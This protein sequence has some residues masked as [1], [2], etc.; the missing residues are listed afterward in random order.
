MS[1]KCLQRKGH[2]RRGCV[3]LLSQHLGHRRIR[4]PGQSQL[5]S[6]SEVSL[7][8]MRPCQSNTEGW[9]KN[10]R[11][12]KRKERRPGDI[13]SVSAPLYDT[14]SLH[15]LQNQV[16]QLGALQAP[17]T[18]VW[19]EQ[20]TGRVRLTENGPMKKQTKFLPLLFSISAYMMDVG[21]RRG[22]LGEPVKFYITL[23]CSLYYKGSINIF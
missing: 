18:N 12:G 10:G 4:S 16:L 17:Y 9:R 14:T 22:C 3:C 20:R 21:E 15:L 19:K 6:Y 11:D 7:R 23:H 2:A 13:F 8:Y 1:L 5:H